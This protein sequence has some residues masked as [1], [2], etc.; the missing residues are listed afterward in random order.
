MFDLEEKAKLKSLPNVKYDLSETKF[1]KV[2][3]DGTICVHFRYYSVPYLLVGKTVFVKIYAHT[4]E[5]YHGLEKVALHNRLTK[6]KGEKSIL[7][8]HIPES[9]QAYRNTTVQSVIQQA[10][11]IDPVLKDFIENLLSESPSG[12]LRRAQGFV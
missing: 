8:E 7:S 1:C 3:P 4:I 12:N 6:Y 11:Y 10:K 9:S 2:H 5:I